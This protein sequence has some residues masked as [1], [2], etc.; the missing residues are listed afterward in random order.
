MK[1]KEIQKLTCLWD[2]LYAP[3]GL[4]G[5]GRWSD[6]HDDVD[7]MKSLAV[8]SGTALVIPELRQVQYLAEIR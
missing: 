1:I 6:D 2:A 4:S 8:A 7:T 3:I 5:T